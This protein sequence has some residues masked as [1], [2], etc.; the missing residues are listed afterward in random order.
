MKVKV[1]IIRASYVSIII[2]YILTLTTIPQGDVIGSAFTSIGLI[3]ALYKILFLNH[4]K[5]KQYF[6]LTIVGILFFV[7]AY[8]TRNYQFAITF[9]F[10]LSATRMSKD[11]LIAIDLKVRVPLIFLVCALG[12]SGV[13]LNRLDY[14]IRGLG[15]DR[16]ALGFTHPNNLG[17]MMMVITIYLFYKKHKNFGVQDYLF[18]LFADYICW[19]VA[20]SR[21]SSI[22]ITGVILV[23]CLDSIV[24][25]F[26]KGMLLQKIKHIAIN[27][28]G[29]LTLVIPLESIYLGMNYSTTP[30]Y[31]AL[32]SLFS[33]RFYLMHTAFKNNGITLLGQYIKVI[34]WTSNVIAEETN[35][36]DNLYGYI[37]INF[38]AIFF[39]V[40]ILTLVI[41]YI[42]ASKKD[43]RKICLC[44]LFFIIAGFCENKML[45]IG[46]NIFTLY[47]AVALYQS[48]MKIRKSVLDD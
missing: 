23:E 21:T 31:I 44:I 1:D 18:L 32:D 28:A 24:S 30:F 14:D 2:G 39:T 40:V 9:I 3:L 8:R 16:Q 35:V 26:V 4:Y 12:Y 33:S 34:P 46:T 20:V 15:L 13:I 48:S 42:Y 45:Y 5:I 17:A 27:I 41:S 10:I 19:S 6:L 47:I 11:K 36:V 38:G 7:S 25:F 43:E 22:I 37:L 29:L